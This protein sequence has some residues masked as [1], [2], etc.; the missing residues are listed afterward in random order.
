MV[1]LNQQRSNKAKM[2]TFFTNKPQTLLDLYN[3]VDP[4]K[5]INFIKSQNEVVSLTYLQ[6]K[7]EALKKLGFLQSKGI[8]TGNPIIIILPDPSDF[9]SMF[10]A[11]IFGSFIA[12][13]L[14]ITDNE[15][16]AKKLIHIIKELKDPFVITDE[17]LSNSFIN[18]TGAFKSIELPEEKI[19]SFEQFT[20][21]FEG[22]IESK[23]SKDDIAY[24]QYSSGSTSNPKGIIMKHRNVI[25]NIDSI[26]ERA[27]ISNS[28]TFISWLP[29]SH[30]MGLLGTHLLPMRASCEQHLMTPNFF[31]RYPVFWIQYAGKVKASVLF[32]PN[33]GF[34]YFLQNFKPERDR[35]ESLNTIRLIFNGAEPINVSLTKRFL[36]ELKP[37]NLHENSVYCGYGMAEAGLIVTIPYPDDHLKYLYLN[38]NLIKVGH[39]M[40]VDETQSES[41]FMALG[42]VIPH[43]EIR[44]CDSK[45]TELPNEYVGNLQIKGKNVTSGYYNNPEA[46]KK[47]F[48]K[49][50]WLKTGDIGT[51]SSIGLLILGRQKEMIIIHGQNYFPH[52]LEQLIENHIIELQGNIIISSHIIDQTEKLIIFI[53]QRKKRDANLQLEQKIKHILSESSGLIASKFVY[54]KSIPKTT[55]GK[56]QRHVLV[57]NYLKTNLPDFTSENETDATKMFQL[58]LSSCFGKKEF[59]FSKSLMDQDCS[60]MQIA[61]LA[62]KLSLY[63]KKSISATDLFEYSTPHNFINYITKKN[64]N[65]STNNTAK[66]ISPF[67]PIAVVGAS[68]IFPGGVKNIDGLWDLLSNQKDVIG[69]IPNDRWPKDKF[70]SSGAPKK[71][72]MYTDKGYFIEDP[73][74]F[75]ASF[76]GL[77][78]DEA[79]SLDP[80]QRL[81]LKATWNTLEDAGI[82]QKEISGSETGVYI[83]LSNI[84]YV[85]SHIRSG[86]TQKIDQ[87][88][89][90]SILHSTAAGRISYF[91]NL[92]GPAITSDT[93][94]S[95]SLVSLHLACNAIQQG[96]CTQALAGGVN[97]IFGPE[98]S[99]ALSQV[100]ALSKDGKCKTFDE[101]AD[102]YGRSEGVGMVL[103]KSLDNAINNN[104][105]ILGV[106][107]SSAINQDGRSNGLTAP[108]GLAQQKL[109]QK[110][111]I[112][113]NIDPN[114]V[115]YIE[116]H[117]TGTPLG[118][119][120]E[121][122]ALDKAYNQNRNASKPL[123][124]GS[125]KSNIGHTESAAG[126]AGFMKVLTSF[127]YGCIPANLH[128][129]NPNP[130]IPWNQFNVKVA[131]Q[132]ID[133]DTTKP[134]IAGVSSFGFSGTNAHIIVESFKNKKTAIQKE[135]IKPY[136]VICL[137]SHRKDALI[138]EIENLHEYSQLNKLN[139]LDLCHTWNTK[140]SVFEFRKSF[141]FETIED[142]HEQIT[143]FKSSDIHQKL[144]NRL[145]ILFSGQGSQYSGMGKELFDLSPIFR[146]NL[147]RCETILKDELPIKL[148]DL[149]FKTEHRHLLNETQYTQVAIC[150]LSYSLY[151]LLLAYEIKASVVCGHS[152][153]EYV[154]ACISGVMKLEDML[155]IVARRGKLMQSLPKETGMI[156]VMTNR[157]VA[158]NLLKENNI[159]LEVAVVN[160]DLQTVFAGVNNEIKKAIKLF[161]NNNIL[162]IQLS[163]SHAFH[164]KVMNPI[165]EEFNDYIKLRSLNDA[166]I[167][168][169]RNKTGLIA[170]NEVL[171]KSQ[172]WADHIR[173]TVDFNSCIDN[174]INDGVTT[175]I[176]LGPSNTLANISQ[177]KEQYKGAS[178]SAIKKGNSAFNSFQEML[179][180][181]FEL[182][183][184]VNWNIEKTIYGGSFITL[185]NRVWIE[186][187][188]WMQPSLPDQ[189]YNVTQQE[190]LQDNRNTL[191]YLDS[192]I[193]NSKQKSPD[194]ENTLYIIQPQHKDFPECYSDF[195]Q[196]SLDI[197]KVSEWNDFNTEV[198]LCIQIPHISNPDPE[199]LEP[200]LKKQLRVLNYLASQKNKI[201]IYLNNFS[202]DIKNENFNYVQFPFI[203]MYRNLSKECDH[204]DLA[205]WNP[206]NDKSSKENYLPIWK[207]TNKIDY[208]NPYNNDGINIVTGGFGAIGR[209][210]CHS[211]L[212][213]G[214]THIYIPSRSD[215]NDDRKQWIKKTNITFNGNVFPI[216]CDIGIV[217]DLKAFFRS[218][219]HKHDSI[220]GIYHLAGTLHDE[221]CGKLTQENF[222]K[223]MRPKLHGSYW[224]HLYSLDL[225]PKYFVLFSSAS[226]FFANPG[227]TS[228]AVANSYLSNLVQLRKELGLPIKSIAWGPWNEG[229]MAENLISSFS[230]L[231]IKP[232]SIAQGLKTLEM[233]LVSKHNELL[234][235]DV[236]PETTTA[237]FMK[238]CLATIE[239]LDT[240]LDKKQKGL[241]IEGLSKRE[242]KERLLDEMNTI[243]KEI[244]K[245]DE[246]T[247]LSNAK[248]Y[249]E[250]G[251]N[252]LSLNQYRSRLNQFLGREIIAISILF[253]HTSI[254]KLA[255]FV[256]DRIVTEAQKPQVEENVKD[257]LES[258]NDLSLIDEVNALSDS[259]IEK[260]INQNY[261][262]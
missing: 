135:Q 18:K 191:Y 128:F 207:K 119:P 47:V 27:K 22:K 205:F 235:L 71:G 258:Y 243:G 145:A 211:L 81:L 133:Y 161:D 55:S 169:Y 12:V 20:S 63:F 244:L 52:D 123:I 262:I 149:I 137:S 232:F 227:Q 170:S 223:V 212:R 152:I 214:A 61:L 190:E 250:V 72:K 150:C 257:I 43:Q 175:F 51:I 198:Q 129:K 122:Q 237:D 200:V 177:G 89:L 4:K 17:N 125:I 67:Q 5:S 228:Y 127:K 217:E 247:P 109:I 124:I 225:N 194:K 131:D 80:Q 162:N 28:D 42:T 88:S 253:K 79:K 114:N 143:N 29:M 136:H 140:K 236:I 163:V 59:D 112:K 94:C 41:Q 107:K 230:S 104:D 224:I 49:D 77:S 234:A 167:P 103:L 85:Q 23:V 246:N 62:E 115:T 165:L 25:Y 142:L 240:T 36:E 238:D 197:S 254:N 21:N 248:S 203:A 178:L 204:I 134:I 46:T 40:I 9:I 111:L 35:I 215:I 231:G 121:I 83:G 15:S 7:E 64:T 144:E 193:C 153:G 68:C 242:I 73:D 93:A 174:M 210:L 180:K 126:I 24:L 38:R 195:S 147:L 90:T 76:F 252:S 97:L 3:A 151:Q 172:S 192:K 6:L 130:L 206:K 183:F 176:E 139:P 58:A 113:G 181:L 14:S 256:L 251:F 166:K 13:P 11:S 260:L 173:E 92:T 196:K 118:D 70:Y 84:D 102:G 99:I 146:F 105:N 117:G 156:S 171:K 202:E 116:T 31:V 157:Y 1:L 37:Y 86:N 201:V 158:E 259:E 216:K 45:D 98:G 229:G 110:A 75:D 222:E 188:Y 57:T 10:W 82:T 226:A 69:S 255:N 19:I 261:K 66:K 159:E 30:D 164:S 249:F 60:S 106:I 33:F 87:Y 108:N 239:G 56:I 138:Q 221:L 218:I 78:E 50:G 208:A 187:S 154:A 233:A 168:I 213:K 160:S 34:G 65:T 91:L 186:K 155:Q 199:L 16:G 26:V 2:N 32:S 219:K 74:I 96:E 245:L 148:T 54:V 141:S 220:R 8:P 184:D 241:N 182:G 100:K 53:K 95:S 120:I 209:E 179:G 101:K 48:T 189:K 132:H 44:I 39:K 185:P